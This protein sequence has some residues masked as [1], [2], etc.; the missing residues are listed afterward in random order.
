VAIN[1]AGEAKDF[2]SPADGLWSV[3]GMRVDA[4]RRLL[5]VCTASHAQMMN[6][7]EREKGVSGI[8]K[9]DLRTKKLI[10]KYL[11]TPGGKDH[12]LGDLVLNSRGDVFASDS[13]NP[14]I[15]VLDQKKDTLELFLANEAFVNPQGLA[16]SADGKHLFMADYLKGVFVIDLK[17]MKP[18]LLT[19]AADST[20]LGLDGLYFYQGRLIGIQNGVT[21]NRLVRLTLN[22][23]QSAITKFDVLE[24]NN[25]AFDE[26]TLAVIAEG[27]LYYNAN[28][29]WGMIDEKGRLAAEE[30]LRDAVILK[31][32]L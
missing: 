6:F 8:F 24:A 26:P 19:P 27:I 14:A 9:Y 3:M 31:L 18:S 11:V 28:S 17:T 20:M 21:P 10:K 12:W 1:N 30:K 23:D 25:P 16:F 22:K 7:N 15:Y 29:Q 4:A 2:S 13:I 32:K 5:W